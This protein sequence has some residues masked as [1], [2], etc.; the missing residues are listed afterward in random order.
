MVET[1]AVEPLT[2]DAFRP[3]GHVLERHGAEQIA[4][5][6][7]AAT[8][9]HRLADIAV[10]SQGTPAISIFRATRRAM[11]VSIDML[12]RHPLASQAFMPLSAH[13]WLI[14][15]AMSPDSAALRC[16]RA[17]GHQGVQFAVGAWH[18][19]LLILE[20]EQDFLVID[21]AESEGNLEVARLQP[22][23]QV[24]V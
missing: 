4:I 3:F 9:Y 16:F 17:S 18:F 15:V 1:L 13:D 2:K 5:N 22:A 11:P 23:G 7:G 14:V 10:D 6:D 20:S 8:R 12:E 21:R 19:P 24:A